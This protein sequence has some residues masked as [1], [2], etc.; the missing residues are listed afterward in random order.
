MPTT[1]CAQMC[2]CRRLRVSE[3]P[4]K[5]QG[6]RLH[7]AKVGE[8]LNPGSPLHRG[9]G[10]ACEETEEL[11]IVSTRRK[12]RGGRVNSP[13]SESARSMNQRI[14]DATS[15]QVIHPI[16]PSGDMSRLI[17]SK[18]YMYENV[19]AMSESMTVPQRTGMKQQKRRCFTSFGLKGGRAWIGGAGPW[20]FQRGGGRGK[21]GSPSVEG[22][23]WG[24]VA[25]AR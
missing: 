20:P 16:G 25:E 9:A 18:A 22:G 1:A 3:R 2:H 19:A 15:T 23:S 10:E 14:V 7:P 5:A 24:I 4:R 13:K 21:V 17:D 8:P 6:R 11:P 12:R